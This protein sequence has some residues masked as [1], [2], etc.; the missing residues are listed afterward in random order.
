MRS[1]DIQI[2]RLFQGF[3]VFHSLACLLI[4]ECR[5]H[6]RAK[7]PKIAH[8]FAN[9]LWFRKLNQFPARQ[10]R[11]RATRAAS[12]VFRLCK[13]LRIEIENICA[14]SQKFWQLFSSP[15]ATWWMSSMQMNLRLLAPS[16]ESEFEFKF[17]AL[18]NL[19]EMHN[20]KVTFILA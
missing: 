9:V 5:Q 1:L 4:L 8:R 6:R 15:G 18:W 11:Q 17:P 3:K 19:A 2:L 7:R 12:F 13:D 10:R 14:S 16:F 20:N